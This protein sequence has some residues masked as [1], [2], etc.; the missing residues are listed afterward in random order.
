M[1]I[2]QL[3]PFPDRGDPDFAALGGVSLSALPRFVDQANALEQS[4]QLV[5]TTGTSTTSLAIGTGSKTLTTQAG[6]AW[7]VGAFVYIAS[8]ASVANLMFGQITAY[9][10]TTGSLTVN[11]L[12]Y[13]GSGTLA[14]WSIGLSVPRGGTETFSGTVYASRF[15]VDSGFALYLSSGAAILNFDADD[16]IRHNRSTNVLEVVI[17][18]TSR[19]AVSSAGPERN[20]D[21]S[22]ANGLVRKSQMDAGLNNTGGGWF[23]KLN[24]SATGSNANVSVVADA[25]VLLST[26]GTAAPQV[27]TPNITINSSATGENGLDT[28]TLAASTW[29][30]VWVIWNGA[31]AAG[32]LSLSAAS[33][34]MPIGYTHRARVGWIRTDG[35]ANRFPLCMR[36]FGRRAEWSPS[37]SANITSYPTVQVGSTSG[38][39]VSVS[40]ASAAPTTACCVL[41]RVRTNGVANASVAAAKSPDACVA[42]GDADVGVVNQSSGY[43][44]MS[45]GQVLLQTEQTIFVKSSND[46]N[47]SVSVVGW[48]DNL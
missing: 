23:R 13:T 48:E 2:D 15:E 3:P 32:L 44:L 8:S 9:N 40:V 35:S 29:Y 42:Y 19:L 11:V 36:Q 24:V 26:S 47:S 28:G 41:I 14:A 46:P 37:A 33:P 27:V 38:S 7:V 12:S 5:A 18:N 30:S 10:S 43:T 39:A 1:P 16:F 22:T 4:L 6:K 25:V 34:A 17:G 21:A 45:V 20:D 31:T